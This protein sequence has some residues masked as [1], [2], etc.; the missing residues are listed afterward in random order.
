MENLAVTFCYLRLTGKI[1][2]LGGGGVSQHPQSPS[3][4]HIN[5]ITSSH[6][7]TTRPA[8]VCWLGKK[9][10][11]LIGYLLTDGPMA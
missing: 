1:S 5:Y 2:L 7:L 11:T 9:F 8:V 4:K 3:L 6:F 10:C